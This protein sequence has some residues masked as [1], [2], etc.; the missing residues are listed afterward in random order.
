MTGRLPIRATPGR[1]CRGLR[2][3]LPDRDRPIQTLVQADRGLP[4][5]QP[6]RLRRIRVQVR[7]LRRSCGNGFPVHD[8]LPV[9][10]AGD[11]VDER[12]DRKRVV[13]AGN[14]RLTD[15]Q[16]VQQCPVQVDEIVDPDEVPD[17]P[18][19]T[20]TADIAGEHLADDPLDDEK[21][22]VAPPV[23]VGLPE[24]DVRELVRVPH[25]SE[26]LLTGQLRHGVWG[27][28]V[29]ARALGE[30]PDT[31]DR[32]RIPVRLHRAC[33]NER[34]QVR[35]ELAARLREVDDGHVVDV[36]DLDVVPERERHFAAGREMHDRF[37]LDGLDEVLDGLVV[38]EVDDVLVAVLD[39]R[40]LGP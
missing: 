35:C 5:Q 28:W 17:R 29:L 22:V 31:L 20:Q 15:R 18:R 34:F 25:V 24:D 37:G 2:V 21:T 27:H 13:R 38:G 33:Q 3:V 19:D 32:P 23:R 1:D 6:L 14:E 16:L 7:D 40:V 39:C 9:E 8:A 11:H 4:A 36:R 12:T 10:L 30:R 26:V